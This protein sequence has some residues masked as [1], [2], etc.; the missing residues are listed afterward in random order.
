MLID[1]DVWFQPIAWIVT[2]P[3]LSVPSESALVSPSTL[4]FSNSA[5]TAR[6]SEPV[7]LDATAEATLAEKARI[8]MAPV[9]VIEAPEP[10]F[11]PTRASV[12]ALGVI[13]ESAA[14]SARAP[15]PPTE[16][17]AVATFAKFPLAARMVTLDEDATL[18]ST[19][20]SVGAPTCA[21]GTLKLMPASPPTEARSL[22]TLATLCDTA[23]K[24]TCPLLLVEAPVP[25]SDSVSAL[26]VTCAMSM[27]PL[28]AKRKPAFNCSV[29]A[30]AK[31]DALA[32]TVTLD[33]LLMV[34]S[35]LARTAPPSI[36]WATIRPSDTP[37][38][39]SPLACAIAWLPRSRHWRSELMMLLSPSAFVCGCLAWLGLLTLAM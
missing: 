26:P 10:E 29:F 13:S 15:R 35:C 16:S 22:C 32:W 31:L 18:P 3:P 6:P 27:A 33:E 2:L 7:R 11:G 20:T 14:T 21:M 9:L 23:V 39:P 24:L 34:P 19:F 36:A 37:P 25:D 30:S 28:P 4:V 17:A 8:W 5:A 1:G 12:L 38:R